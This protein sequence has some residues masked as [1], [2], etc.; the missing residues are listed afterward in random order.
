M[1]LSQEF[2]YKYLL[3][4]GGYDCIGCIIDHIGYW[5]WDQT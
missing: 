4:E 5:G 2:F 3:L 1:K